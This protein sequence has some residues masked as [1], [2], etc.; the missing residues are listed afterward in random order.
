[1]E[2]EDQKAEEQEEFT[3]E[4]LID[5]LKAKKFKKIVFMTG[6]GISVSAG[7]PDFRS[8]K[9]GLF[10]NLK[11]FDLP[12]PEAIFDIGFFQS[13]PEAFFKLAA[14]F[15]DLEK[16]EATPTHHFCK[17]LYDKEMVLHY[18][19]QN[20]DNLESKA[21]FT[22]DQ[23]VMAHGGNR[24]ATGSKCKKLQ[25]RKALEE[26]MAKG[27]VMYCKDESCLCP[28]KPNITFYGEGLPHSFLEILMGLEAA[29]P[30]LL[31]VIGT[32]LAVAPFNQVVNILEKKCPAVLINLENTD[33]QGYQFDDKKNYP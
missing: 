9:T 17:M 23:N 20:I 1:M 18:L 11:E 19:T 13:K 21:G 22:E 16:F 15:M 12:R 30:D 4:K 2:K 6:A 7:I 3:Y 27:E 28:V 32:A 26:H 33:A 10:D 25:D 31:I 29:E 24:G 14:T 5:G 8:P